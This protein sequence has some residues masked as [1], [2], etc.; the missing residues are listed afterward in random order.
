MPLP[1]F[2]VGSLGSALRSARVADFSP[3]Q[4][5][6]LTYGRGIDTTQMREVLGFEPRYTTAEAFADFAD[7]L[8]PTGGHVERLVAGSPTGCPAPPSASR[9]SPSGRGQRDG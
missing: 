4:L 2:A 9:P 7:G 6:F 1:G 8:E 3:E 5:T